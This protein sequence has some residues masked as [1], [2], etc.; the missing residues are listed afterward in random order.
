MASRAGWKAP[1]PMMGGFQPN[2]VQA[3]QRVPAVLAGVSS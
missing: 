1:L 2:L 3:F